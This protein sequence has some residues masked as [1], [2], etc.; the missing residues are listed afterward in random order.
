MDINTLADKA[1]NTCIEIIQH[2]QF[3]IRSTRQGRGNIKN[4]NLN[5]TVKI[6]SLRN[7]IHVYYRRNIVPSLRQ[8]NQWEIIAA[9]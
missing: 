6:K 9:L 7:H 5:L 2:Y 8:I 4:I 3:L 1:T